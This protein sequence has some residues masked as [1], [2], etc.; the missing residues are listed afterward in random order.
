MLVTS[1]SGK[2]S[3]GLAS[4]SIVLELNAVPQFAVEVPQAH[5][6]SPELRKLIHES[7]QGTWKD[8]NLKAEIRFEVLTANSI[9]AGEHEPRLSLQGRMIVPAV[10]K[11][12]DEVSAHLDCWHLA[13]RRNGESLAV[14]C[15]RLFSDKLDA[16]ADTAP[17]NRQ[18]PVGC[19]VI[20][21][22]D[23]DNR[24]FLERF[25][26][27]LRERWSRVLGWTVSATEEQSPIR[28]AIVPVDHQT[29]SRLTLDND[30]WS[31]NASSPVGLVGNFWRA[32]QVRRYVR[33]DWDRDW[34]LEAVLKDQPQIATPT[35]GVY[36]IHDRLFICLRTEI[37]RREIADMPAHEVIA[38][39]APYSSVS[40]QYPQLPATELH[41][42]AT[43]Q[44]WGDNGGVKVE[45]D[46]A[47]CV[48]TG[49]GA[50]LDTVNP[51]VAEY[52]TP[53]PPRGNFAGMYYTPQVQTPVMVQVSNGAVPHVAGGP[54]SRC[55]ALE[56]VALSINGES[57]ALST[58]P[59]DQDLATANRLELAGETALLKSH[60]LATI[61]ADEV[62][63][64]GSQSKVAIAADTVVSRNLLVAGRVEMG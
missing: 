43:M 51:L 52:Y 7:A 19:T 27:W 8:G 57:L 4:T 62:A 59:R 64:Q 47:V 29:I 39:F 38:Y 35:P 48:L 34:N 10:Q 17:P 32:Q 16:L 28:M 12:L 2:L 33:T 24:Q 53:A 56:A 37:I 42:P 30:L 55:Q 26:G 63:M 61:Q 25:T 14:F 21:P 3:A 50:T 40:F 44:G 9:L 58:S 46:R 5:H 20:R 31:L 1:N 13:Q 6:E 54:Q 11:W 49:S 18:I 23:L 15:S 22:G 36:R 41:L 45:I 60:Q